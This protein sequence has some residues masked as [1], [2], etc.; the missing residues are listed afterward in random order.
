MALR[1]RQAR[2]ADVD[3]VTDVLIAAMPG[4][5]KWWNYRFPHREQHPEDHRWFLSLLIRTW[6]SP[7][8]EDMVVMV[9]E[10]PDAAA[11]GAYRIGAYAAWDL[12]YLNKRK[13][14]QSYRGPSGESLSPSVGNCSM[15]GNYADPTGFRIPQPAR[16]SRPRAGTRGATPTWRVPW[17]TRWPTTAA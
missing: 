5:L 4:D 12:T 17:R 1:I 13:H 9:A 11:G 15:P 8:F 10:W 7:E 3:E 16:S 14:G 2:E 6:I